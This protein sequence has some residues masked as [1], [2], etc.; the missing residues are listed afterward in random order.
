[1]ASAAMETDSGGSTEQ[2]KDSD[3]VS[4]EL[5][6]LYQLCREEEEAAAHAA[7]TAAVSELPCF[8]LSPDAQDTPELS[9]PPA[10]PTVSLPIALLAHIGRLQSLFSD[11]ASA[12]LLYPVLLSR[13]LHLLPQSVTPLSFRLSVVSLLSL[14]MLPP[15]TTAVSCQSF[16]S[17]HLYRLTSLLLPPSLLSSSVAVALLRLVDSLL[18]EPGS[19]SRSVGINVR[20][21]IEGW[22]EERERRRRKRRTDDTTAYFAAGG[23]LNTANATATAAAASN[24]G[25][26]ELKE[27]VADSGFE[28]GGVMVAGKRRR[29]IEPDPSIASLFTSYPTAEEED[30]RATELIEQLRAEQKMALTE[31]KLRPKKESI[32]DEWRTEWRRWMDEEDEDYAEELAEADTND[33]DQVR[34]QR[35]WQRWYED[36]EWSRF[37]P[38]STTD[39][40][41]R[42]NRPA[43]RKD[44]MTSSEVAGA[45]EDDD[46]IAL[47]AAERAQV[48]AARHLASSTSFPSLPAASLPSTHHVHPSR[49]AAAA[50]ASVVAPP[51]TPAFHQMPMNQ[52]FALPFAPAPFVPPFVQYE[53]PFPPAF[54]PSHAY[55]GGMQ[56]F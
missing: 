27:E 29:R 10:S 28:G 36:R 2:T 15:A 42:S 44:S 52:P 49:A 23:E 16:F 46:I 5:D 55:R 31:K 32:E 11:S 3:G 25:R 6:T 56:R 38:S 18:A 22:K 17:S 33:V 24:G 12:T 14:L 48:E 45:G 53:Q 47:S 8:T 26:G 50:A 39:S 4:N 9:T 43:K 34:K 7:A 20:K 37:L 21:Y 13:L 30:K 41:P 54:V 1:M 40:K 35:F 51:Y 19:I